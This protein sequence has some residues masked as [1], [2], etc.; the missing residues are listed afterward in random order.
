MHPVDRPCE[1]RLI[2]FLGEPSIWKRLL[3]RNLLVILLFAR[4]RYPWAVASANECWIS[5]AKKMLKCL[6][7]S[8]RRLNPE[9]IPEYTVIIPSIHGY[10]CLF[11]D[12]DYF[13]KN[14]RHCCRMLQRVVGIVRTIA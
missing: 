8:L 4:T 1:T 10:C 11:V 2:R 6:V 5:E 3:T 7:H 13:S 9:R 12:D 14:L